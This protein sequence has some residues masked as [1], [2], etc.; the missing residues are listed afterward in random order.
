MATAFRSS[1]SST[2]LPILLVAAV[3]LT[4][5]GATVTHLHFF[6]HDLVTA[7]NPTAV[8]VTQPVDPSSGFGVTVV[9][10]DAMT[11]GPDPSSTPVGRRRGS[12]WCTISIMGRNPVLNHE[13]EI[14]VV[15]GTGHFRQGRGYA[16]LKTYSVNATTRNAVV[17]Y[18]VYSALWVVNLATAG[19]EPLRRKEKSSASRLTSI[20]THVVLLGGDVEIRCLPRA[21]AADHVQVALASSSEHLQ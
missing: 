7:P 8:I 2:I 10:D 18:D 17:E 14:P 12:T 1:C 19:E 13:R 9:I 21:L 6:W 20:A 11:E 3:S 5:A 15:G 16:L 4:A